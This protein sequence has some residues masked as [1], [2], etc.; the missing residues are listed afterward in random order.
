MSAMMRIKSAMGKD[1]DLLQLLFVT[2]D[3][4]RD[5]QEVLKAYMENFDPTFLALRPAPQE[6][7]QVA[8]AFR[9]FY[10]RV[11]GK[12]AT[13]YT[14]DHTASSYVYDL[15]GKLRLLAPYGMNEKAFQQDIDLLIEEER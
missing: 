15:Q 5:S 6:L 9:V 2:V 14:M 3:P 4:E 8:E 12:T 1:G 13:S 11:E 7:S 10:R